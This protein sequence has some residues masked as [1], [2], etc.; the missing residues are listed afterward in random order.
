MAYQ[1]FARHA[2]SLYLQS[3]V[4]LI[5]NIAG[6][7]SN[8]IRVLGNTIGNGLNLSDFPAAQQMLINHLNSNFS[9]DN[10]MHTA[11]QQE[12]Q[13]KGYPTIYRNV[14]VSNGSECAY[15]QNFQPDATLLT[16][17]GSGSTTFLT[18]LISNIAM[19]DLGLTVY[20]NLALTLNKPQFLLG[21]LPGKS[22]LA[23]N[24]LC[25]AQPAIGTNDLIY[26]GKITFTK[27]LLWLIDIN[28]TITNKSFNSTPSILP[29]DGSPGGFYDLGINLQSSS[30]Q[31][32]FLNYGITASNIP[33]F[34]FVPTTSSLDI[35]S[36]ATA[37]TTEDYNAHYIGGQPPVAPHK[38]PFNNFTTAF[39]QLVSTSAGVKENNENH[40]LIAPRNGTWVAEELNGNDPKSDCSA[41]CGNTAITGPDNFCTSGIFSV[42]DPGTNASV[43]W[44]A[45]PAIVSFGS[46]G[47][48][49]TTANW[50]ADGT[51]TL[52]A[53]ITSNTDCFGSYTIPVSKTVSVGTV[54]NGYYNV[55]SNY[56]VSNNNTLSYGGGSVFNPSNQ[57][58]LFSSQISTPITGSSW[59]VSGNYTYYYSGSSFFNLYMITP[60]NAYQSN[61]ATVTLNATGPCGQF[62]RSYN[63]QAVSSGSSHYGII[64]ITP[65]PANNTISVAQLGTTSIDPA[66]TN[67]LSSIEANGVVSNR[68]GVDALT[69]NKK[70]VQLLGIN[71]VRIFDMGGRLMKII[72]VSATKQLH[73]DVSSFTP[74]V[75]MVEIT[76]GTNIERQKI[77]VQH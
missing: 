22:T 58:V 70:P 65:N 28:T 59:S 63:F 10:S 40:I 43:S 68:A 5:L 71:M 20:S 1:Y 6:T 16:Y 74:G 69:S 41:A 73:V 52:T 45:I 55:S 13:T 7:V 27:K 15:N 48:P 64:K 54:I 2:R 67:K 25:K 36:G 21:I 57:S 56:T 3:S 39:D 33:Q 66:A 12:L 77:V 61:N 4:P 53:T 44:T 32:T 30:L 35:G 72:E 42:P 31:S 34:N 19:P 37:L 8:T 49:Q 24:F 51:A 38:S 9:L 14:A 75:Y 23:F 17:N 26:S 46:P 60:A 18:E 29:I 62:S 50:L 47:S 76:S 11:W